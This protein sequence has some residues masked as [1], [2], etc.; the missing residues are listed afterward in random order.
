MAGLLHL[1]QQ[2]GTGR[3]CSPRR[4]L[5]AVLNVSAH[6]SAASVLITVLLY[7]GPLPCGSNVPIKVLMLLSER[8]QSKHPSCSAFS[9]FRDSQSV[10]DAAFCVLGQFRR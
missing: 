10:V 4:P 8:R 6:P 3:G 7:N 9:I 1:V 5:L 2:G